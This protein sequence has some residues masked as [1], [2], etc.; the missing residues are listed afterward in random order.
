MPGGDW[1]E[2]A[3]CL[4]ESAPVSWAQVV[5]LREYPALTSEYAR[6]VRV[7]HSISSI[8]VSEVLWRSIPVFQTRKASI[9]IAILHATCT[10]PL[11]KYPNIP[12][13]KA[14]YR[15]RKYL[16][17]ARVILQY[18]AWGMQILCY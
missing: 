11:A 12:Q 10:R 17:A 8:P 4:G 1:R 5:R 15:W 14:K 2:T 6:R 16:S 13:A 3:R 7:F 9:F 18:W